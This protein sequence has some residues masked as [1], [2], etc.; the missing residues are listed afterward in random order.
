MVVRVMDKKEVGNGDRI[1]QWFGFT[2]GQGMV[3]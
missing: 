2:Q 1:C 3:Q